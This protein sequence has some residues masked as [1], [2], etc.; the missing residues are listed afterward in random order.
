MDVAIGATYVPVSRHIIITTIFTLALFFLLASAFVLAPLA[1]AMQENS[2]LHW[3]ANKTLWDRKNNT[4]TLVGN[5]VISQVGET[6]TSDE[7]VLD[8]NSREVN[9]KGHC[10]YVASEAVIQGQEMTFNLDDRTGTVFMGRVSNEQFTLTGDRIDRLGESRFITK[11]GS[12]STCRDCPQSWTFEADDVDVTFGGYAH[13]KNVT[14]LVKESPVFWMPYL[15]LPVKTDRQTGLLFPKFGFSNEGFNFVQPF[16]WAINRSADMTLGLG[17]FGGRGIRAETEARYR[18][19]EGSFATINF[20]Y[21][22]DSFFRQDL[23]S[24]NQINNRDDRVTPHRWN[25]SVEQAQSLPF[26]IVEKL[27]IRDVSDNLYPSDF[28]GDV[29][30]NGDP[31]LPSTLILSHN[32]NQVSSYVAANRYRNLL[33]PDPISFDPNTVQVY[34]KAEITTNNKFLFGLPVASGFTLGVSNFTRT[35]AAFDRDSFFGAPA[36]SGSFVPGVD[37]IRKATRVSYTPSLYTTLRPFDILEFVP[38]AEYRG[39]Y[40]SFHNEIPSLTRGYVLGQATL[41]TQIERVMD[42]DDPEIPKLK[43]LIRPTLTYSVI[44][45][46]HENYAGRSNGATHPFLQQMEY[47][48]TNGFSGYNFDNEDIVPRDESRNYNN[49]FAPL[50]NSLSYGFSTQWIRRRGIQSIDQPTYQRIIEWSV[51]QTYNF[52]ELKR[53][54]DDRQPFSKAYSNFIFDFDKWTAGLNYE[55]FP[56]LP[57]N[58]TSSRHAVS[59]SATYTWEKGFKQNIL[60]FERSVNVGYTLRRTGSETSNL[61]G[62]MNYSISDYLMPNAYSDYDFIKPQWLGVGGGVRFQ[63]P[64]QCWQLDLSAERR[65][66]DRPNGFCFNF[67]LDLALNITG[68]GFG[69][70]S[71]A[72]TKTGVQSAQ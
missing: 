11:N 24:K 54:A 53:P 44:P 56:Y 38:S 29:Y 12:Y 15:I 47:A 1:F 67:S 16:F 69:G 51:G 22:R 10:V 60:Y 57:I 19:S 62:K 43:H 23:E 34:P 3:S 30:S 7:A 42:M 37:P 27:R 63:S 25:L 6:L 40:Y 50:G 26:G 35:A 31:A 52:R 9:A 20:N 55:Y 48:K 32:T 2:P 46:D 68:N 49:Y 72:A 5:A 17:D 41:S 8:L 39:Y 36:T 4:V 65:T 28:S 71:E 61:R 70:L 33:T 18:L 14:G 45:Y 58:E 21:L 59:T 13:L 66:C 64:S